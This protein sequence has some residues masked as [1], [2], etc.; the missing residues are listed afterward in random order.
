MKKLIKLLGFCVALMIL[1]QAIELLSNAAFLEERQLIE[2][3]NMEPSA[4]FYTES[5][6]ALEAEK[7][8]RQRLTQP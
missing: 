7:Q 5:V 6:H 8:I 4:I 3:Q 1:Q 2:D